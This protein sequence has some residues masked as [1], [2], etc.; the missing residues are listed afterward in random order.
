MDGLYA[1]F[2][3]A[4]KQVTKKLLFLDVPLVT[5]CVVATA[6]KHSMGDGPILL[7]FKCLSP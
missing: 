4:Q 5:R 3:G 7:V 1:C 6:A 2:T